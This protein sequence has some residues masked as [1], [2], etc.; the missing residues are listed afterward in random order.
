MCRIKFTFYNRRVQCSIMTWKDTQYIK[1]LHIAKSHSAFK[2]HPK[3]KEYKMS[4]RKSTFR[5]VFLKSNNLGVILTKK[6]QYFTPLI[7][8]AIAL[9]LCSYFLDIQIN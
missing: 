3:N 7:L 8:A 5:L 1:R 6:M 4:H 9:T 2:A